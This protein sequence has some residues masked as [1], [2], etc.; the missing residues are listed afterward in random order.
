MVF[1]DEFGRGRYADTGE[2]YEGYTCYVDGTECIAF[3][4]RFG[5]INICVASILRAFAE[6][7]RPAPSTRKRQ[8]LRWT[9]LVVLLSLLVAVAVFELF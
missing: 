6:S 9:L 2:E 3:E 8:A 5:G 1:N 4:D 7:T